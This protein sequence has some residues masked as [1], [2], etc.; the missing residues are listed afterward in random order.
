MDITEMAN[1]VKPLLP[2]TNQ[3]NQSKKLTTSLL[4]LLLLYVGLSLL[5]LSFVVVYAAV[6]NSFE[7]TTDVTFI[8][9]YLVHCK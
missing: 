8:N 9:L 3:K 5:L 7:K 1:N 4:L 6:R 2:Q